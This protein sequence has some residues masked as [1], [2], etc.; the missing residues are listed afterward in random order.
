MKDFSTYYNPEAGGAERVWK[1]VIK[2][3]P[4]YR[5]TGIST[6]R[7]DL[8]CRDIVVIGGD[9]TLNR[10]LNEL[11]KPEEHRYILLP[12]GTSNSLYSQLSPGLTA[13]AKWQQ[14]L[15]GKAV[16]KQLDLPELTVNGKTWRFINEASA[17]FAGAIAREIEGRGTKRRFSRLGLNELAYIAT[18]FRCWRKD[19]SQMLSLCNNRRISGDLYPC[20]D[21]KIDDGLIDVFALHCP[22]IRLPRELMRLVKA[23]KPTLSKYVQREQVRSGKWVF[24]KPLPVE[25]DGNPIGETREL[26]M[27]LYASPVEVF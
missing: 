18:A 20:P 9:G 17:G 10:L 13:E 8:S 12:G 24:D 2:V 5:D 27:A 14:Y 1:E 21:A 15:S 16:F 4:E 26:R 19:E 11:E 23:K 7:H 22:R 3:L 25:I 6:Y